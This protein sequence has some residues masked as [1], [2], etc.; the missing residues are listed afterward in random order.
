MFI[1]LRGGCKIKEHVAVVSFHP[2]L[3]NVND[4]AMQKRL[5]V[6]VLILRF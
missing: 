2:W 1:D 4:D 6:N 3:D 5:H